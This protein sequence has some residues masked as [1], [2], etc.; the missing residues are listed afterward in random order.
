MPSQ[1]VSLSVSFEEF[2]ETPQGWSE[3]LAIVK[4]NPNTHHW[5]VL[6]G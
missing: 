1:F 2:L 5:C 6:Y 4:A 3:R